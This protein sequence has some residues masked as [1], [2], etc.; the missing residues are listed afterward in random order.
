MTKLAIA[1]LAAVMLAKPAP[2]VAGDKPTDPG[3]KP[4]SYVPHHHT[5]HHVYGAPI[6]PAIVGH[7]KTLHHK[8]A[9]KERS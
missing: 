3:A 8:H 1:A 5:S 2:S 6:G 7:K 4:N 9:P